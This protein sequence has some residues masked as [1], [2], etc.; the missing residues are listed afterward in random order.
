MS[1]PACSPNAGRGAAEA[2]LPGGGGA[3][4]LRSSRARDDGRTVAELMGYGATLLTRA[5]V[6][7]GT[8]E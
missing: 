4:H 2:Q 6:M 5:D 7:D 1:W 3:D 8:P